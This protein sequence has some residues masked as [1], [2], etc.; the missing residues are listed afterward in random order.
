MK[1]KSDNKEIDQSAINAIIA[2]VKS[3]VPMSDTDIKLLVSI[4]QYK[5]VKK[6]EL[7]LK[8]GEVCRNAY[9]LVSGFLRMYYIDMEGNEIN[10]RFTGKNNFLVDFQSFLTQKPSR[11]FWKAME[12]SELLVLP[13]PQ[14]QNAYTVSPAWNTFGRLIAEQVYLQLNERVEMLLFMNPE[15]R[16]LHLLHTRPELFEQVSQFHLSSYLGVKP[17]SLSRLRKRLSKK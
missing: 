11:F 2:A 14:I 9:F 1:E 8:E 10:Y 16:Y 13:H 6:N 7:L 3:I 4:L 5:T 17:E 15:E 12:D